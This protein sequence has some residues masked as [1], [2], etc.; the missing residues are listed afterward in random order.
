MAHL[1][2]GEVEQVLAVEDQLAANETLL[3]ALTSP[4]W[5]LK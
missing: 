4:S 5:V 1:L 2:L 3:T